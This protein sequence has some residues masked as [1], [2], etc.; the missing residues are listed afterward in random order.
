M[1]ERDAAGVVGVWMR[2]GFGRRAVRRPARVGH[3]ELG[4]RE[5]VTV[6]L[7]RAFKNADPPDRAANVKLAGVVD[8]R[9]AGRVVAAILEALQSF[10]QQRL[11]DL[12]ADVRDDSAHG[13]LLLTRSAVERAGAQSLA[14]RS[15]VW[16]M[17]PA[18]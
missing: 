13:E 8:H 14:R 11:S 18:S 6:I 9:D 2:V 7:D 12:A 4:G 15:L 16:R 5:R 3:A 1:D 17:L 10:D